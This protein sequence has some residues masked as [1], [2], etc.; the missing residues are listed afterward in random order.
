MGLLRWNDDI[1]IGSITAKKTNVPHRLVGSSNN[2]V[3][4]NHMVQLGLCSRLLHLDKVN[5]IPDRRS[6]PSGSQNSCS[7]LL[8]GRLWLELGSN[9]EISYQPEESHNNEG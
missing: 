3:L 4:Y 9:A 5:I 8:K 1:T 7:D 6:V 2:D